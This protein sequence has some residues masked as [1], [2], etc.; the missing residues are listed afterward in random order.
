MEKI[1]LTGKI[2]GKRARGRQMIT[3]LQRIA[4]WS[5]VS[6]VELIQCTENRNE[7]H[8]LVADVIRQ[9]TR[10]RAAT[11]TKRLF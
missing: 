5:G 3:F 2:A 7:W 8:K 10:R 6:G 1:V 11:E 9:D 4:E